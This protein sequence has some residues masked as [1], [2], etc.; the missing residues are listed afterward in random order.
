M[1]PSGPVTIAKDESII[2]SGNRYGFAG[3]PSA[4]SVNCSQSY[5]SK[6]QLLRSTQQQR[7]LSCL[8]GLCPK[9]T[10]Y[11]QARVHSVYFDTRDWK[12][13]SNKLES[14]FIKLKV[15]LR[16]YSDPIH[17]VCDPSVFLEIKRR[18]GSQREKRRLLFPVSGTE[19]SERGCYMEVV[20]LVHE[21]LPEL[22][23]TVPA[24]LFPAFEVRYHR[25][26]FVD[27]TTQSRL[28][29]DS[30]ITVPTV[31]PTRGSSNYQPNLENV[32]LELKGPVANLPRHLSK[33]ETVGLRKSSFSKFATCANNILHLKF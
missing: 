12:L 33:I 21:L 17:H 14:D 27:F 6:Y 15:R 31:F 1:P 28:S 24:G 16:W 3:N 4:K 10:Q 9:D 11:P 26:R 20:R 5:E 7:L 22:G 19:I 13:L 29:I 23:M 25:S 2:R 8:E 32:I 18:V 30:Q